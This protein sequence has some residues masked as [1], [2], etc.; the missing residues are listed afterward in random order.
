MDLEVKNPD[1]AT[2]ESLKGRVPDKWIAKIRTETLMREREDLCKKLWQSPLTLD[3]T[4]EHCIRERLDA[5]KKELLH[6]YQ[7][8][9]T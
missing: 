2:W 7:W 3:S 8:G 5:N 6:L 1:S 9:N 4:S